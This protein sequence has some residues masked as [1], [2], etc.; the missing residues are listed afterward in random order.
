MR[1]KNPMSRGRLSMLLVAAVLAIFAI[2]GTST[3]MAACSQPFN[4][5]AGDD[6]DQASGSGALSDW[7]DIASSVTPADDPAK[8]NDT[9][10]SGGDKETQPG[11]WNF[12][13]GNNT[14][15]T[16]ILEGWSH[17]ESQFLD[18]AFVRAKQNG[19]T[20]LAF[21][22]NQL[23]AAPRTGTTSPLYPQ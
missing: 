3:A 6:G 1:S 7:Q 21:E 8:G 10:F 9:K 17:L 14:P 23:P 2:A 16:D 4:C 20:F 19:D 18:V 12:I 13:T 15:K 22:L 11:G 5:F